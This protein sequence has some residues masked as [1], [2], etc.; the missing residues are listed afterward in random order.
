MVDLNNLGDVM[1]APT[2]QGAPA[3]AETAATIR[4]FSGRFRS[5]VRIA[6]GK[7]MENDEYKRLRNEE[8]K[9][10]LS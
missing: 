7:I 9:K 2:S 5:S 3:T 6:V 1:D 4:A 10:P 8:L